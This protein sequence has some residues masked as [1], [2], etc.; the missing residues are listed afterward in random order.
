MG[1]TAELRDDDWL[2]A[3]ILEGARGAGIT[4]AG[5]TSHD[6]ALESLRRSEERFRSVVE[7]IQEAVFMTE[8]T[9]V[10]YSNRAFS[11]L[12]G[13]TPTAGTPVEAARLLHPDEATR[14]ARQIAEL[15]VE[16]PATHAE[17][18]MRST[19]GR[20]ITLETSAIG[21]GVDGK[22]TVL[23]LAQD[24]TQRRLLEGQLLQADRLSAL[25]TLAAGMAHAINN[26]LSYTLLNLEHVARRMRA[27]AAGNDYYAEARVRLAEAHDGADRVAKVVRQMR[28]LSRARGS[29]PGAVDVR[30]VL[31]NV[32]AMIG[33]EIRYRGQLVTRFETVPKVWARE[34]ELDQAFLGLL[35]Y[36]AR[37]RPEEISQ[38]REISLFVGQD[39]NG[40]LIRV[41]DDGPPLDA[42]MRARL[43]D[44]FASGE[45]MGLGLAMCNAIFTGLG[46]HMDVES[47]PGLGTMFSVSLPASGADVAQD[48]QKR[49]SFPPGPPLGPLETR[50]RVLVIDDDPGV[51]STL[52][53]MLELHHQVTSVESAREGLR[54]LLGEERFDI[55]FCDLV[56][57]E[58]SGIDLYCALELNRPEATKRIVFMTGGVF[59]PEAEKF[60]ARVPN[61]RIEK[62]F[63]LSRVEQLLAQ[64][65]RGRTTPT[66]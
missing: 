38:G 50:L 21:V 66:T 14:F 52:R 34:G 61:L 19:E 58:V 55:A 57:P 11:A 37:S 40:A 42:E 24:V 43:L 26:P 27:F 10:T 39:A 9:L 63:S 15:S 2:R 12:L 22:P 59:T 30:A 41:S 49:P 45:T 44:P 46:G 29:G 60:L 16:G 36:V 17:Y 48:S 1:E 23:W 20:E 35:L 32:L 31:E 65:V 53:A 5:S 33:N 64:A 7:S 25:G 4:L 54:L 62:P 8:G 56:M 3:T 6:D 47:A 51:S 28:T 18:R 13:V